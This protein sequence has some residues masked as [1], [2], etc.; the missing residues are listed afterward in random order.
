[1]MVQE[2][3]NLSRYIVNITEEIYPIQAETYIN[4]SAISCNGQDLK[5][6]ADRRN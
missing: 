4:A 2:M 6:V 1:M 3:K 5:A